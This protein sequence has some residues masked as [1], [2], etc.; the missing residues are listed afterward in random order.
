M[1]GSI[2]KTDV[3]V[4]RSSHPQK[5]P[6]L[7]RESVRYRQTRLKSR[8]RESSARD[9]RGAS[10]SLIT[11]TQTLLRGMTNTRN[12]IVGFIHPRNVVN[13]FFS[14][15]PRTTK[16]K[17]VPLYEDASNL[18]VNDYFSNPLEIRKVDVYNVPASLCLQHPTIKVMIERKLHGSLPKRRR[19]GHKLGL[20]V[21]GGG[22]RGAVSGAML[23][24]LRKLGFFDVFDTV[25][26]S[27]AGAVNSAYFLT[28]QE[29]GM[30]IYFK[31]LTSKSFIDFKRLFGPEPVLNLKLLV[32]CIMHEV[33]PL[34]W[35]GVLNSRI[36]LKV[37][38]SSLDQLKSVTLGEFRNK[39][40]LA[41][42]LRAS[43][44]VPEIVGPP[45]VLDGQRLVD[46]AVFEPIPYQAAIL[47]GCTHVLAL[48]SRSRPRGTRGK[49]K[50]VMKKIMDR[51][52]KRFVL[53]PP[54]M[55]GAWKAEVES[56]LEGG[57][58]SDD[59]ML[60]TMMQGLQGLTPTPV[61]GQVFA[62]Y[63]STKYTIPPTCIDQELLRNGAE[64]ARKSV[65]RLFRPL[66]KSVV[67]KNERNCL[68]MMSQYLNSNSSCQLALQNLVL[69]RRRQRKTLVRRRGVF[70]S[71]V[72]TV[73]AVPWTQQRLKHVL[74]AQQF[75][76]ESLQTIFKTAKE[77]ECVQRNTTEARQLEGYIMATLFYEPSTRT[78][79]SFESAMTRLGG[80]V[81]TTESAGEYSSA[82]KGET[83]EGEHWICEKP[84]TPVLSVDTIRTIEGYSD[85][86]VLRHNLA[87]SAKNAANAA[88]IPIIN[89]GDGPGQHPTQ[90]LLDVY[91]IERELGRLDNFSI[92]MVGDL[93]NGRTVRSLAYLL[94]MY[95]NV[96]MYFVSPE[97]VRMKDDIKSFL[98]QCGVNWEEADDLK[99]VASELDILYQTRIQK[100]RF[101][102]KPE[103]FDKAKG[104][105][106]IDSEFMKI[107]PPDGVIMHPL[108]RVD[109][110]SYNHQTILLVY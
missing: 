44:T 6:L 90:A 36:P 8:A 76:R 13:Q 82:A 79:L 19:D 20:V 105:I 14:R 104:K 59:L 95:K 87:G 98:T 50:R 97:V 34:D 64:E 18:N 109:E 3:F 77:M 100:E 51:A 39:E 81:L 71:C 61:G 108:P 27:S 60:L 55:N 32:D 70:R 47:D 17:E 69:R 96:K 66:A 43:C 25:Y 31:H 35:E 28:G 85:V 57:M 73:E 107:F 74:E 1:H 72:K 15:R 67:S 84:D 54:Y 4:F 68:T 101:Q 75:S 38:A 62:I 63:P 103:D 30:D 88:S 89:A 23:M 58:D 7:T 2:H 110:V 40:D 46:A 9:R 22:M 52:V 80:T 26:G 21:E 11:R 12:S 99:E 94:S 48:C 37:I 56:M 24:Q 106:I 86:I 65:D 91:T 78:R 53:N 42:A 93:A 83:L 29:Y 5:R 33:V 41:T 92:G 102:Y 16:T 49:V 45:E 10:Q